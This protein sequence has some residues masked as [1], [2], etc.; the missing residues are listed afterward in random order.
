MRINTLQNTYITLLDEDNKTI[1]NSMIFLYGAPGTGK[2]LSME[3][4]IEEFHDRGYTVLILS[5]VKD[6][7]EFGFSMFEPEKP[8]HVHML[9]KIGKPIKTRKVKI[10]HPFTFEIPTNKML[11]EMNFYGFSIKRLNRS[12]WSLLAEAEFESDTIRLLMNSRQAISDNDGIYSFLHYLE[13][14]V[15]GKKEH[16]IIKRDPKNFNLRVTGAT[17][18]S[19]QDVAS[20][21][22]PFEKN[23]FL[24]DENSSLRLDWK[25]ILNDQESYHF[26][27]THFLEDDKLKQFC[28]LGLLNQII[29]NTKE[30]GLAKR[31]L[32]IVIPEIRH[33]IPYNP[34]GYRKFLSDEIKRSLSI[35]RNIGK[36]GMSILLDSQ[37]WK[38]VSEDVRNTGNFTCYG[39]LGG[40][41]DIEALSKAL[42]Y[43]RKYKEKLTKMPHKMTYLI[44]GEEKFMADP[45][46][47]M[48]VP[49]H[50]HKE[51]GY[52][53][54]EMY[55]KHCDER[56]RKI[57]E[58]N[59]KIIL[60]KKEI[61]EMKNN[62]LES[63][64][65]KS[66]DIKKIEIEINNYPMFEM[67]NYKDLVDS[68]NKHLQVEKDKVKEK[69]KREAK[70]EKEKLD[71]LKKEKESS[72]S[73]EK[74]EEL[75]EKIKLKDSEAVSE[76]MKQV[77]LLKSENPE[78][79][80][81]KIGERLVLNHITAKKYYEKYT[82]KDTPTTINSDTEK[83]VNSGEEEKDFE[84][85]FL[86]EDEE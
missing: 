55:K 46:F 6:N 29:A 23:Y 36:E 61:E 54:T 67:K 38:D 83:K 86:E 79:S 20:Y 2:T 30:I 56:K 51:Q 35:V 16:K 65:E 57:F 43:T 4:L 40:E 27:S 15:I 74:V 18:K 72:G 22:K 34:K 24:V 70:L 73:E 62:S 31:P 47:T 66:Y 77:Y 21:L 12:E 50:M 78:M 76:R 14:S 3:S 53:F 82:S 71:A 41:S 5:D 28:V 69:M 37:V 42:G 85:E 80:W 11:P 75:K 81:R 10:Y 33:M 13:D 17:P 84:E 9:Q 59:E 49:G 48:W 44:K 39:E 8:Y 63:I 25:K 7:F 68:M 64:N 52:D 19:M 32:L 45:I 58:M 1:S 26:F 60:I